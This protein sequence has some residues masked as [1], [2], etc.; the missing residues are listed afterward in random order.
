M[1]NYA[2]GK[3]LASSGK[4]FEFMIDDFEKA[5]GA[6]ALD[7]VLLGEVTAQ[8]SL[9]L[10]H[11]GLSPED[12]LPE[13]LVKTLINKFN[14]AVEQ[15]NHQVIGQ[16]RDLEFFNLQTVRLLNTMLKQ[17]VFRLGDKALISLAQSCP[18]SKIMKKLKINTVDELIKT[19]N[20]A[21]LLTV[22]WDLESD[23]WKGQ[24]VARISDMTPNHFER[25]EI[26]F[27]TL[28]PRLA[29]LDK[30]PDNFIRNSL[31][32]TVLF[33]PLSKMPSHGILSALIEGLSSA[34]KMIDEANQLQLIVLSHN[35][36]SLIVEWLIN[37][38]NIV[39]QINS[40]ILPWRS[41]M[42]ALAKAGNLNDGLRKL[43]SKLSFA[44]LD[45]SDELFA[46]FP[47]L[48]FWEKTDYL[49]YRYNNQIIS[50]SLLD[51]ANPAYGDFSYGLHQE[52]SEALWDELLFRYLNQANLSA[53]VL[54]F[55]RA[56]IVA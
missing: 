6:Q 30:R 4:L 14:S 12:T 43:Y 40:S 39:W 55:I 53:R 7:V 20:I 56:Q 45:V 28:D 25:Q 17:K 27:V 11:L 24:I 41:V 29:G 49:A 32:G 46:Q 51:L 3:M 16:N 5:S 19:F 13:E 50:L 2:L 18:P 47:C 37:H 22:A 21:E 23:E 48:Q 35:Y 31:L 44:E 54:T 9:H 34:K 52:F 38:R 1:T 36:P 10:R 15:V 8:T 42:R 33:K 26:Y